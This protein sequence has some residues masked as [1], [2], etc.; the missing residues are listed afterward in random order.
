MFRG[1]AFSAS[2]SARPTV[3]IREQTRRFG[4]GNKISHSPQLT[5]KEQQHNPVVLVPTRTRVRSYYAIEAIKTA[6]RRPRYSV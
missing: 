6:S 3:S 5:A 4:F 1:S 2:S